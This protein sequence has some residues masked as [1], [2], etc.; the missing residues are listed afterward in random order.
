[1]PPLLTRFSSS[2]AAERAAQVSTRTTSQAA[3]ARVD[4]GVETHTSSA[5]FVRRPLEFGYL[6]F[7]PRL[8]DFPDH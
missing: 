5:R 4:N 1:M 6:R 7:R 2:T 3:P 8:Y